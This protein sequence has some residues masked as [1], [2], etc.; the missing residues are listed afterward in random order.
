MDGMGARVA[1]LAHHF[2]RLDRLDQP[3]RTWVGLSVDDIDA[4]R[5]DA[6]NDEVA[7]LQEGMARHWRERRTAGVP[8]EV[9][10]FV[11]GVGHDELVD[12]GAIRGRLRIEVDDGQGIG[13]RPVRRQ[14]RRV[15]K[16]FRCR[17]HRQ[18]RRWVK[19][20]I[21]TQGLQHHSPQE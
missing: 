3:W 5:A 16:Q 9:V 11:A 4:R 14:Q 18:P 8:A 20:G 7:A 2:L 13:P 6:G 10:E 17:F 12:H 1:R 15:G 21:G 19:R